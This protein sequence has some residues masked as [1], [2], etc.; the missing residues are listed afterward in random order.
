MLVSQKLHRKHDPADTLTSR[1]VSQYTAAVSRHSACGIWLRPPQETNHP[2]GE[3]VSAIPVLFLA[4]VSAS[5]ASGRAQSARLETSHVVLWGVGLGVLD[6]PHAPA[7]HLGLEGVWS[8]RPGKPG[9]EERPGGCIVQHLQS[10]TDHRRRA[11][12]DASSHTCKCPNCS[13]G[14]GQRVDRTV[15]SS[16]DYFPFHCSW[17]PP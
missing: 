13:Q 15:L 5:R 11:Q 17:L 8:L 12:P 10:D 2:C 16:I 4:L 3:D 1:T 6:P 9:G 7:L 14:A